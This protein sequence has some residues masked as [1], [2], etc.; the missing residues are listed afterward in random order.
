MKEKE[1]KITTIKITNLSTKA[2]NE[3]LTE[4]LKTAF[5]EELI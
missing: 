1:S 5:K 3:L 2:H 4:N